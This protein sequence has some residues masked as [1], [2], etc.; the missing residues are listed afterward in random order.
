[1]SHRASYWK[2]TLSAFGGAAAGSLAIWALIL[3]HLPALIRE[4]MLVPPALL[5]VGSVLVAAGGLVCLWRDARNSAG[6][7]DVY[8]RA[9]VRVPAPGLWSRLLPP[10]LRGGLRPGELVRVRSASEIESTLDARGELDGLPFMPEMRG[11]CGRVLRVHRRIDKINDMRHKTGLRR[12]Q[13]AVTLTGARCDG[14]AHGGCQAECQIIWRERWLERVPASQA[15]A[16]AR[17]LNAA[18]ERQEA[19]QSESPDRVYVCQMTRL[20]EA[21]RPMSIRDFRQDVRPLLDGNVGFGAWLIAMLT[22]LFTRVQILRGGVGFPYFPQFSSGGPTPTADLKLAAGEKVYVCN[23][24][25]IAATL[26]NARNR[27]LWFDRDMIRFCG[28]PAVVHKRVERVIHEATGRMIVMKIPCIALEDVLGTG[29]FLRLC[30]QHEYM[31]WREV[32]LRR[33]D[34]D[35]AE[36]GR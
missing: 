22:R 21:S 10:F 25:E 12:V 18:R 31:F 26:V 5:L 7:E 2:T 9:A 4:L 11:F 33:A 14:S 1:V 6:R 34:A 17:A 32:W 19:Q 28:R 23:R 3:W 27:G 20:W 36:S 24:E 15:G 29:E 8:A 35:A 13:G 16:D 30:S